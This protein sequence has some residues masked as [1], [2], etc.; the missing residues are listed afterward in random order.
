MTETILGLLR[1]GQTDWNVE[2]RLQGTSDIALNATGLAQAQAAAE[3][4]DP[5]D[6]DILLSSP[7]SRAHQTAQRISQLH[8]LHDITV[9]ERFLERAFGEA[10]GLSYEQW[11]ILHDP[12]IG[13]AGGESLEQLEF[14]ANRLLS[15]IAFD[16]AGKR[17]LAV[18]HGSLI[19]KLVRIA[20]KKTL[21]REGER[22]AN[23]SLTKLVHNDGEWSILHYDGRSLAGF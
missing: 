21:P 12:A 5:S 10:E 8:G 2:G 11:K 9:D 3:A 23:T 6:W 18:S 7:L 20:S 4:I 13:V 22:F 14:R 16:Y 19:R 17:V 15:E 1:H